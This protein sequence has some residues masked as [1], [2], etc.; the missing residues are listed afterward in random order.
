MEGRL[1][2]SLVK[3]REAMEKCTGLQICRD[4]TSYH[5]RLNKTSP[6]DNPDDLLW[7]A[8]D[9]EISQQG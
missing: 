3:P 2:F 6:P 5:I 8:S 1:I 4:T 7:W 9:Q